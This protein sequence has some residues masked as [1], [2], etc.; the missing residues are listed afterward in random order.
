MMDPQLIKI[1]LGGLTLLGMI[2]LV[3]GIGLALAAHK[4]AVEHNP[5]VEEVKEHL[6]G[7]QCGGC[8]FPGCESYAE[9]VVEDPEV[10]TTLCFPGKEETAKII[11]KITGK[12]LGSVESLIAVVHCSKVCGE[13]K[14]KYNYVGDKTCA[15][16]SL[17]FGGPLSCQYGCVGFGD[18]EVACQFG[19]IEMVDEFPVVDPDKCNACGA[20]VKACPKFV[21]KLVPR[22]ARVFIPCS[23]KDS[24]KETASICTTG[25]I[26]CKAC[27][28]K[29]PAEAISE[30]DG[31][32]TVDQKKC[33][34]YGPSCETVCLST[35]K[36]TFILQQFE[37]IEHKERLITKAKEPVEPVAEAVA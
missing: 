19:A 36:K 11:A 31:I 8:G 35:C 6:P 33:L 26:H 15:G 2:G 37:M 22:E 34:A 18:C 9:A 7:A 13:V 32:I 12:A 27:V 10:S 1:A 5:K 24:P 29:C 4:F 3:F 28:K 14:K 17:A 20:C 30:V 23:T 21:F 16:A 25:C